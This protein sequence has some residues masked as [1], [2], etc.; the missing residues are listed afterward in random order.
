[1]YRVYACLSLVSGCSL[2]TTPDFSV[3]LE[4]LLPNLGGTSGVW[5][6]EN[7]AVVYFEPD[8]AR[9]TN[10]PLV[11]MAPECVPERVSLR[12]R[13]PGHLWTSVE[14]VLAR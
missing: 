13:T 12:R 11:F 7:S 10:S 5:A 6:C 2:H 8:A 9:A 14:P 4:R 3:S 1:M